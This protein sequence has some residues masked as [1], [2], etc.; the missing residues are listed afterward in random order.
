MNEKI[1]NLT[2]FRDNYSG[3]RNWHAIDK[4]SSVYI[5]FEQNR[6]LG[7]G[8]F[9]RIRIPKYGTLLDTNRT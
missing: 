6:K 2:I 4:S 9:E 8:I 7:I 1:N 5:N 3:A